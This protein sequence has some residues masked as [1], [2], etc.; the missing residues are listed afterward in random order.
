MNGPGFADRAEAGRRLGEEISRHIFRRPVLVF[1][2]ARGGVPVAAEVARTLG[3]PLD[4]I[5]VR[6]VGHPLDAELALGAVTADGTFTDAGVNWMPVDRATRDERIARAVAEAGQLEEALRG[7]A[8]ARDLSGETCVVVDD[9]VATGASLRAAVR[10][11]RARGAAAVIAAAPVASPS[12]VRLLA[13]DADEVMVA[14]VSA[15]HSAVSAYYDDFPAVGADE[16]IALLE[17]ARGE[18]PT[19]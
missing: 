17:S 11:V 12:A 10:A 15:M 5:V 14:L 3:S 9:G 18:V 1:G 4:V 2:V 13:N 6:K 16:V 8:P 7:P 19:L